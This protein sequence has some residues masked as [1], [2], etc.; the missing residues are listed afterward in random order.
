MPLWLIHSLTW[1]GLATA[2]YFSMMEVTVFLSFT[3]REREKRTE[4]PT[5]QL[6]TQ[7]LQYV[8]RY[9][10]LREFTFILPSETSQEEISFVTSS[11]VQERQPKV[12]SKGINNL[13]HASTK[14]LGSHPWLPINEAS[15]SL[16][17]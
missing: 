11:M 4:Y 15:R 13:Y 17:N 7:E 14:N 3:A 1:K 10:L 8:M 2:H 5:T 12:N 9:Q 16:F 6:Y